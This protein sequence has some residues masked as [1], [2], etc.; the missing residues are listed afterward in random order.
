MSVYCVSCVLHDFYCCCFTIITAAAASLLP[1]DDNEVWLMEMTIQLSV[2][3]GFGAEEVRVQ[4]QNEAWG[5][6]RFESDS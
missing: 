2:C 1:L 6:I 4:C 5:V 3:V